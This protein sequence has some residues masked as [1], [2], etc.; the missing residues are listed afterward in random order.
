MTSPRLRTRFDRDGYAYFRGA[1]DAEL[2]RAARQEV[3]DRLVDVGEI[4]PASDGQFTGRSERDVLHPDRGEFWRSVST[5]PRLRRLSQGDGVRRLVELLIDD[6]VVP[7]DYLMLRVA[8]PGR[9]TEV[10]YD[11]PFFARLH[12][13]VRTVWIPVGDV[14]VERGPLFIVEGSNRFDDII[15]GMLDFEVTGESSRTAAFT[16]TAIDIAEQA[17]YTPVDHGLR[18]RGRAHLR[19]VHRPWQPRP[20][21]RQRHRSHLV[22]RPLAG[23]APRTR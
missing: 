15:A 7:L 18:R 3:L 6:E 14:P 11:Y 22:R 16:Q 23:E 20:P 17:E 4:E 21:R 9:A 5:G 8:V 12:D 13:Q 2:V 19:H 1:L 10:H